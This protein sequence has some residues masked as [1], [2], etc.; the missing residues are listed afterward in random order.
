M[1]GEKRGRVET[2]I[3]VY[4]D[5]SGGDDG[6]YLYTLVTFLCLNQK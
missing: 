3:E 4:R 1:I 2:K 5:Q 6:R